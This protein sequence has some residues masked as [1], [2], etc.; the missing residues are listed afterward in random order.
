MMEQLLEQQL[1]GELKFKI[2]PINLGNRFNREAPLKKIS[3][4]MK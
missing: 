1:L 2:K 3:M 4:T